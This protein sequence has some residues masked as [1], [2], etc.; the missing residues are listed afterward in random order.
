MMA[1]GLCSGGHQLKFI[2]EDAQ[3][4]ADLRDYLEHL[5]EIFIARLE[6]CRRGTLVGLMMCLPAHRS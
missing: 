5:V 6:A 1:G 4:Q 2:A 3:L